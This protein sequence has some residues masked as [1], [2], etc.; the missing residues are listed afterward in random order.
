MV[1][2]ETDKK[3]EKNRYDS[4]SKN[5][6]SN[7]DSFGFVYSDSI[8]PIYRAPYKYFE[9]SIYKHI[10][11][12]NEVLELGSGS[13]LH[14]KTLL[15]TGAKVTASDISPASLELLKVG[16]ISEFGNNLI[17]VVADME[18]LPFE[19]ESFDVITSAGSLSYAELG[20]VISEI[21]RLL[22]KDGYFICVDS[23]N[24]NPIYRL[25]RYI[26][27]LRGNRSY[28]TL[29]RMPNQKTIKFIEKEFMNVGIKYFGIFAFLGG[30]LTKLFG[31]VRAAEILDSLDQRMYFLNK[32]SFKI[33]IIA[34]N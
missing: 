9:D 19:D 28:S 3:I 22:K 25:N 18:C 20:K 17:T 24:H 2:E 27:Y 12:E 30:F 33:V 31:K 13:G 23:F 21:K 11:P 15:L 16:L 34:Q 7:V 10:K 26:H 32:Y 29:Q 4:R 8:S 14:T 6:L 1:R 5:A